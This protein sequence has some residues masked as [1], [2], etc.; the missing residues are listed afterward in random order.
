MA[1]ILPKTGASIQGKQAGQR[2][3]SYSIA[4][5]KNAEIC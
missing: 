3:D 2:L 4:P 5:N 1:R